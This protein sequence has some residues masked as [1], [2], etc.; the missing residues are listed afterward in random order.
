MLITRWE[1]QVFIHNYK[2]PEIKPKHCHME[3][4]NLFAK[5]CSI[6]CYTRSHSQD[7]RTLYLSVGDTVIKIDIYK[8]IQ[9]LKASEGFYQEATE[10]L[11][12][13]SKNPLL[14]VVYSLLYHAWVF[15][16]VPPFSSLMHIQRMYHVQ[17]RH[18]IKLKMPT[19]P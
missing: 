4:S 8:T 19:I 12:S 13:V 2:I 3:E 15:R 10:H 1:T 11:F 16:L 18:K 6:Y 9:L 5:L 17:L 7:S 14:S